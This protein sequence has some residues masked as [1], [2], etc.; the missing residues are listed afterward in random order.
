MMDEGKNWK[1]RT[2]RGYRSV[3]W[4][5]CGRFL[6]GKG[7][8]VR[9]IRFVGPRVKIS[10]QVR[11]CLRSV[12]ILGHENVSTVRWGQ[13]SRAIKEGTTSDKKLVMHLKCGN[14]WYDN[15]QPTR[16]S[17]N[18][19]RSPL[20]TAWRMRCKV[21]IIAGQIENKITNG[22]EIKAFVSRSRMHEHEPRL[23]WTGVIARDIMFT[24][25]LL[26]FV[27]YWSWIYIWSRAAMKR[28]R[29]TFISI[30]PDFYRNTW[31]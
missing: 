17:Q 30:S 10:L 6:R 15:K 8:F 9:R 13:R 21:K 27:K 16:N 28:S 25:P 2:S 26:I 12:D 29:S 22:G 24:D 11:K 23:Q 1:G 19:K 18:D 20:C 5:A 31:Y 3:W 7:I 14:F 4:Q